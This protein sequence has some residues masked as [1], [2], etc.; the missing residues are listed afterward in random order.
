[1]TSKRIRSNVRLV[2]LGFPY[3]F[4]YGSYL[5]MRFR[6]SD[7]MYYATVIED[8]ASAGITFKEV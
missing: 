4:I 3:D 5:K 8:C 1:M 7:H 6:S 2:Q